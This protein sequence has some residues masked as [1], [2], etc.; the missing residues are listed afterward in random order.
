MQ[1][2]LEKAV[3]GYVGQQMEEN[4]AGWFSF[5]S[6][7]IV[8]LFGMIMAVAGTSYYQHQKLKKAHYF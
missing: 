5:S 6:V 2:H 4:A 3:K 8:L 1:P 7:A